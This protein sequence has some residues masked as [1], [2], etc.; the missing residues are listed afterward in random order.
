ML[1][2][3]AVVLLVLWLLGVAGAFAIGAFVHVL[4]VVAIVVFIFGL[5]GGRRSGYS[6][7]PNRAFTRLLLPSPASDQENDA[8]GQ[9][10]AARDWGERQRLGLVVRDLQRPHVDDLLFRGPLIPP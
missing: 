3:I 4:L 9:A 7:V 6:R 5:L 10:D 8:G 1:Y 2:T